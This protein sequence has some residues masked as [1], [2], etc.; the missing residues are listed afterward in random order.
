MPRG[1]RYVIIAAVGCLACAGLF[2]WLLQPEKPKFSFNRSYEAVSATYQAGGA[3]CQPTAID[4][5]P[6]RKRQA[7]TDACNETKEQHRQAASSLV[8]ARRQADAAD[9]GT[10]LAYKQTGIAGWG[11]AVGLLTL[12]AALT[13][14][15]F[16]ERAAHHTKR[17]ADSAIQANQAARAWIVLQDHAHNRLQNSSI[18]GMLVSDG[19][20]IKPTYRNA[21]STPALETDMWQAVSFIGVNDPVPSFTGRGAK[22][23]ESTTLAQGAIFGSNPVGLN[24]DQFSRFKNGSIDIIIFTKIEY[25]DV[26][27][28]VETDPKRVTETVVRVVHQGAFE[29]PDGKVENLAFTAGGRDKM[30]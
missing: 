24:T 12:F 11:T 10:I 16:A 26:F 27:Q 7:K 23:V 20:I 5:L 1:Y 14:A 8:E 18:N 3:S 15:I 2:G 21:G 4:R 30:T 9:A 6:R 13:A 28:D 25:F 17:S 19:Y 29:G 22:F